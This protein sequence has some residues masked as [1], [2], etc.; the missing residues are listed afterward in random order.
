MHDI[1]GKV[2]HVGDE[3]T[4]FA[5]GFCKIVSVQHEDNVEKEG[6]MV[7]CTNVKGEALVPFRLGANQ[8][9]K[10]RT[11]KQMGIEALAIQNACNL[12]G[13]VISFS[14]IIREVRARL[15]SEKRCSS[16]DVHNHPVC[17][18]FSDKIASLT[19]TQIMGNDEVQKA[20]RWALDMKGGA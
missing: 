20:Y 19:N 13:V 9:V 4:C 17:R 8:S 16:D 18:L 11:W 6:A 15:E 12:S 14:H 10:V 1:N 2:L 3:I 7:N 5:Y